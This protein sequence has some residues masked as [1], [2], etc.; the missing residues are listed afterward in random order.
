M[1]SGR[2]KEVLYDSETMLRLVDHELEELR[3]VPDASARDTDLNAWLDVF[4]QANVDIGAIIDAVRTGRD[5]LHASIST[6]APAELA[7]VVTLLSSVERGLTGISKL[8]GAVQG[9]Q[10]TPA[11]SD[12]ASRSPSASAFDAEGRQAAAD[13]FVRERHAS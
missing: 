9:V 8:L 11:E 6:S 13:A 2:A 7:Q 1:T 5:T 4:R 12:A 3:D 10:S